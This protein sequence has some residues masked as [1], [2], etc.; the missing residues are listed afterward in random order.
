MASVSPALGFPP[1][2]C[3]WG[4]GCSVVAAE[5]GRS[6]LARGAVG[7]LLAIDVGTVTRQVSVSD[8]LPTALLT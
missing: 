8:P 5:V 2:C 4:W 6:G 7:S 3:G 1:C